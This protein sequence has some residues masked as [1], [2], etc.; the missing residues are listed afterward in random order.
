[1][2]TDAVPRAIPR[3]P[4]DQLSRVPSPPPAHGVVVL[5]PDPAPALLLEPLEDDPVPLLPDP[6]EEPDVPTPVLPWW[7]LWLRRM[8]DPDREPEVSV[9]V[10]VAPLPD[11][12]EPVEVLP[13]VPLPL[14]VV[15]LPLPVVPL[16]VPVVPVALPAVVPVPLPALAEPDWAIATEGTSSALSNNASNVRFMTFLSAPLSARRAYDLQAAYQ[17]GR[18]LKRALPRTACRLGQA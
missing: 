16:P 5:D 9:P 15:P 10:P 7:L 17:V 3:G 12:L 8:L 13:V 11:P 14:P 1:L 2:M 6:D 18:S 4:R